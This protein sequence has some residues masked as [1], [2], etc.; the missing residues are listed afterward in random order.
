MVVGRSALSNEIVCRG[1]VR[2]DQLVGVAYW[3]WVQE[4]HV[5]G[6]H[7]RCLES[8]ML[9]RRARELALV[10]GVILLPIVQTPL[11]GLPQPEAEPEQ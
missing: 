4:A 11:E 6:R 9:R 7:L 5:A 3:R 8:W 1:Y 10:E 2:N